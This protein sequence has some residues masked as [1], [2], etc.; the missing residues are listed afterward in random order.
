LNAVDDGTSLLRESAVRTLDCDDTLLS[1]EDARMSM[2]E[3]RP[4]LD[5]GDRI[6]VWGHSC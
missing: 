1:H 2:I 3:Y 4:D 5:H 6:H